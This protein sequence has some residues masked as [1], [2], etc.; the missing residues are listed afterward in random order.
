MTGTGA[1]RDGLEADYILDVYLLD[2][3]EDLPRELVQYGPDGDV[4]PGEA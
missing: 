4:L 1:G 2:G 3:A